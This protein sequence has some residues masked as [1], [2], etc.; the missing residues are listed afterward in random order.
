MDER[1]GRVPRLDLLAEEKLDFAGVAGREG[2]KDG[3]GEGGKHFC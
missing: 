3:G 2:G 1:R